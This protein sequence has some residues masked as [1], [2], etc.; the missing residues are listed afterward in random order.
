MLRG[1][2]AKRPEEAR[3][4][5]SPNLGKIHLIYQQKKVTKKKQNRLILPIPSK[6][7]MKWYQ[8][9]ISTPL[10]TLPHTPLTQKPKNIKNK[11]SSKTQKAQ[12]KKKKNPYISKNF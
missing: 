10:S 6:P 3:N 7:S 4:G 9:H 12:K 5:L 11:P 1:E 8:H 2:I